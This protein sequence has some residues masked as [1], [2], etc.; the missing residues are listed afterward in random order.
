MKITGENLG[1]W[2]L[3]PPDTVIEVEKEALT[4]EELTVFLQRFS[5]QAHQSMHQNA[6]TLVFKAPL[7]EGALEQLAEC[8]K[9]R[10]ESL[11]LPHVSFHVDKN[12]LQQPAFLAALRS[13]PFI[14]LKRL[15]LVFSKE[16]L[17]TS[18]Q[19]IASHLEKNVLDLIQYPVMICE[20]ATDQP[21]KDG[22][23]NP[24]V[25][26]VIERIQ[27]YNQAQRWNIGVSK[28]PLEPTR[29]EFQPLDKTIPLKTLIKPRGSPSRGD[30]DLFI[31]LEVQHIEVEQLQ[32]TEVINELM[33]VTMQQQETEEIGIYEGKWIDFY[34]LTHHY[35]IKPELHGVFEKELF[36]YMPRA[37]AFLTPAAAQKI[38]ENQTSLV[39]FNI[40]NL[41]H[42]FVLKKR[43]DKFHRVRT[44]VE[45]DDWQLILD[46]DPAAERVTN[47][48][49][50]KEGLAPLS[51]IP[52][53]PIEL[54]A[55]VKEKVLA[56]HL[57]S[58]SK[59]LDNLWIRYGDKGVDYFL[60]ALKGLDEQHSGL[61]TFVMNH[62]LRYFPH[63][64]HFLDGN[65]F[66]DAL[67]KI[68][69]YETD[70]IRCFKAFLENR[71]NSPFDFKDM[72]YGFETFW[73]EWE[74]LAK[75]NEV[76]PADIIGKWAQ[77]SVGNPIVYME[78][79]ITILKNARN[80]H[81]QVAC[82]SR[83]D[84]TSSTPLFLDNYGPYHA[85]KE[86]L[87]IVGPDM[88]FNYDPSFE[89]KYAFQGK[90]EGLYQETWQTLYSAAELAFYFPK[91]RQEKFL[92][93]AYRF[94]GQQPKGVR[95][96]DFVL[97]LQAVLKNPD[98]SRLK[99]TIAE[100]VMT[101]LF[102]VVHERY[103]G[104]L[105]VEALLEGV[106]GGVIESKDPFDPK[107][108]P[109][110]DLKLIPSLITF[111]EQGIHLNEREGIA[112]CQSINLLEATRDIDKEK[113]IEKLF[114]SLKHN[115]YATLNYLNFLST[116]CVFESDRRVFEGET[117]WT[118]GIL[119]R[120]FT[121]AL[122]TTN[123]LMQHQGLANFYGEDL[124]LFSELINERLNEQGVL[125]APGRWCSGPTD[126]TRERNYYEGLSKEEVGCG[127]LKLTH[128]PSKLIGSKFH[129]VYSELSQALKAQ[130]ITVEKPIYIICNTQTGTYKIGYAAFNYDRGSFYR[131]KEIKDKKLRERL[132]TYAS[133]NA[134]EITALE[135]VILIDIL[136]HAWSDDK[137]LYACRCLKRDVLYQLLNKHDGLILYKDL[138]F[139]NTRS[140]REP[141]C[142]PQ[143]LNTLSIDDQEQ[144]KAL[145]N[146][147]KDDELY[148]ATPEQLKKIQPLVNRPNYLINDLD[149]VKAILLQGISDTPNNIVCAY[150]A[151]VSARQYFKSPQFIKAFKEIGAL[152]LY[153]PKAVETILTK[154]G[155]VL[156]TDLPEVFSRNSQSVRHA[157]ISLLLALET[158]HFGSLNP[159]LD[160][161]DVQARMARAAV[162]EEL[163]IKALRDLLTEA[164]KSPASTMM[165][166]VT[167]IALK[168]LLLQLKHAVFNEAFQQVDKGPCL[169]VIKTKLI[170]LPEFVQ[171]NDFEKINL[172][173]GQAETLVTLLS[174]I[175]ARPNFKSHQVEMT[176]LFN[177][178]VDFSNYDYNTILRLFSVFHA[179]PFRDY[180]V[181]LKDF[182]VHSNHHKKSKEQRLELISL[183]ERLHELDFPSP[184]IAKC[185]GFYALT[186]DSTF[187][188]FLTKVVIL[189]Q[190]NKKDELLQF[191]ME[192]KQ[193]EAPL[194][195]S[196]KTLTE[197]L[198]ADNNAI[199]H[200][201][202]Q[203][204]LSKSSVFS[205]FINQLKKYP[206]RASEKI[207]TIIAACYEST[208]S[209]ILASTPVDYVRLSQRLSQ[210]PPVDLEKL[211]DFLAKYKVS[212][213]S[214][215]ASLQR[216][217]P[218]TPID[219]LLRQFEK[220][221][222]GSRDLKQQFDTTEVERIINKLM[223]LNRALS[224]PYAYRKQLME[225]LLFVNRA[226]LDLPVYRNK[227]ARELSNDDIRALFQEI[228]AGQQ[229]HLEPFNRQVYAL[230]LMREAMYRTTGQFPYSTQM[231][232][233][234]DCMM[235]KGHVISNIDTGQGKSLVDTMKAALLWLDST[236]V[237]ISSSSVIDAKR[238]VDIYRSFLSLLDIPHSKDPITASSPIE[239]Y[240]TNGIN[241]STLAQ[242]A[243]FFS[244]AKGEQ[245][246]IGQPSDIVSL[247]MNE[248]DDAIFDDRTIY[249]FAIMGGEG[250]LGE[251]HE[252]IYD[253]INQFVEK[254]AFRA[255]MTS[256]QQD[257][258]SL[259]RF[260]H[261]QAIERK[262]SP[263]ILA[264]LGDDKLL[265]FIES[266]IMVNYRL[267]ENVD[268]ILPKEP[269]MKQINGKLKKTRTV[270]L[271][272][273]DAKVSVDMQYGNGMQQ[274]LYAKLN[275]KFGEG[276]F[277][278][279]PESKTVISLNNKNM[280]DFYR[281]KGGRIWGS[282]GTVGGDKEID[283]QYQKYGFVCSKVE[284]HQRKRVKEHKAD[285]FEDEKTQFKKIIQH[286]K[287]H[288]LLK[289]QNPPVL[290]F[291]KDIETAERFYK[292]LKQHYPAANSQFYMG[293][294]NE[295]QIIR[296]AAL[297]NKITVTTPALGRN[298]DILY[299]KTIGMDVIQTFIG[300]A[301][302][303]R[304]RSG[305]T[306]RQGSKGEVYFYLNATDFKGKTKAQMQ[307]ELDE[308]SEN[309]RRF[310]EELYN[311]LGALLVFVDGADKTFYRE[312][313][314]VFSDQVEQ[315]YRA[316]QQNNTYQRETFLEEVLVKFNQISERKI[317]KE[318]LVAYKA[319]AVVEDVPCTKEVK[320]S[321]CIAPELVAYHFMDPAGN[322]PSPLY[323]KALVTEKLEKLFS[324]VHKKT[325]ATFNND[326]LSYLNSG[327]ASMA[328]IR[329]AHQAFLSEY[330]KKHAADADKQ[331]FISRWFGFNSQLNKLSKDGDYLLLFKTMI[332]ISGQSLSVDAVL[333]A[334]KALLKEYLQTSWFVSREKKKQMQQL[335]T[336]VGTCHDLPSLVECLSTRKMQVLR[337]DININKSSFWRRKVKP[338][339]ASKTSRF[340]TTLDSALSLCA[341]LA[342][343][344]SDAKFIDELTGVYKE[345]IV[346]P[347][348]FSLFSVKKSVDLFKNQM[349]G[350]QYLDKANAK[351]IERSLNMALE[352]ELPTCF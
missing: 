215:D 190:K 58:A 311:L 157:M 90:T 267:Q 18:A 251:A 318:S 74:A 117:V 29:K 338:V 30:Y 14:Q 28:A 337:S 314:S 228:K 208:P 156:K 6:L 191:M 340:Q 95:V 46:Y 214:L 158:G 216:R 241:Y 234:L 82:L 262:K 83:L 67:D 33:Q 330:L 326:Y 327:H 217:L 154:H 131:E 133:K 344:K 222:F 230:G 277:V 174:G 274:L 201:F 93:Q 66:I 297:P 100:I 13:L 210:L 182:F 101:A 245:Q 97:G 51:P 96:D 212:L 296:E 205:L 345:T 275:R 198:I 334:I 219:E 122:D 143:Y 43:Y 111:F 247:V 164:W 118:S 179:M 166:Y 102:F 53:Y 255:G 292:D 112:L 211:S 170:Q 183:I 138:I 229:A 321:A 7:S 63:W 119:A 209:R 5:K 288:R 87:Y 162:L 320:L 283:I 128:D 27:Q 64:D 12:R 336:A 31:K 220:S 178:H 120:P 145:M 159:N 310:N 105:S 243:L 235:Q 151:I 124:L 125:Q 207:I 352:R 1:C 169:N 47:A 264:S 246:S 263:K 16:E 332:D 231:I 260:L 141:Y 91:K 305:R 76:N 62:Y 196:I 309:E 279:E 343:G 265:M 130:I 60:D 98:R 301:R 103:K 57:D 161:P 351:V 317:S 206:Q 163:D 144:L 69:G 306:G 304:Q 142:S 280:I 146:D 85:S 147:Q 287:S 186:T 56:F 23:F 109:F 250:L 278:I 184:Y 42:N 45:A 281:S 261:S 150:K 257:I 349:Q 258:E 270:K 17:K 11:L 2:L 135:D 333:P 77:Y 237:D 70:K 80:L 92:Q 65:E 107:S 136:L 218:T 348:A 36:G 187:D 134:T 299:D 152:D 140:P 3:S 268:Y 41:P 155:F 232:A 15:S 298:T 300:Q 221:P 225:A 139:Y 175:M 303:E 239:A 40:D 44:N 8:F 285:I 269:E 284:P 126:G 329:E 240:I 312:Q 192:M 236:R 59:Q 224:K 50:P 181:L 38:E 35:K 21:S 193:E 195:F 114:Q 266:A 200:L 324:A 315:Q 137:N 293:F 39:T 313:W 22:L 89:A 272:M 94:I 84:G 37:I 328:L 276:Q 148:L 226:G 290:I 171:A 75:K 188:D 108:L 48:Y 177:Q 9:T 347:E 55:T 346:K 106:A 339:N 189:F 244:K 24:F 68:K 176:Q 168:P 104:E 72:V 252:W 185:M 73:S 149:E 254:A 132:A 129:I 203:M 289:K 173:F 88:G 271:L 341:S 81:E 121:Y 19:E 322:I 238:D 167:K 153:D 61:S 319:E 4:A 165:S 99:K 295:E 323:S 291:F 54:P 213:V 34:G 113:Y 307:A 302:Q 233:I 350:V 32:Q 227:P 71:D 197:G 256:E 202:R 52:I 110:K 194:C 286:L 26:R 123:Y 10:P 160:D 249:R 282:S 273:K 180:Q 78:R 242:L 253:A 20:E 223:N 335:I 25:M 294:G 172:M 259:K 116:Q 331:S 199:A 115:N 79:L 49:T 86:G 248:S 308:K 204:Y 342:P 127:L 325:F 316:Q